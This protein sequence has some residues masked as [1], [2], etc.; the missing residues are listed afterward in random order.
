VLSVSFLT[1]NLTKVSIRSFFKTE[2][3]FMVRIETQIL[4]IYLKKKERRKLCCQS[5]LGWLS[6]LHNNDV[7][8]FVQ[9]VKSEGPIQAYS[10]GLN[11]P[12]FKPQNPTARLHILGQRATECPTYKG[13]K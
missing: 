2:V 12:H 13:N 4:K 1:K 11:L 9:S 6:H 5:S 8:D 7:W 10:L 3:L